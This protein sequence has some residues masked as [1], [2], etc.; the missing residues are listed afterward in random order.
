LH[1]TVNGIFQLALAWYYTGDA[2]Y[3]AQAKVFARHWFLD[4]ATAMNANMNFGQGIPCRPVPTL[5][6]GIG[7]IEF[8]GGY[9]SDLID[10]LAILDLGAP[11]WTAAD[12]AAMRAWLREFFTWLTT[13]QTMDGGLADP[14]MEAVSLNNHGSWYDSSVASL[15]AYLGE[16]ATVTAM[17]DSGKKRIDD[18]IDGTGAQYRELARTQAWHYSIYNATALCRLAETASQFGTNLWTYVGTSGGTV[19]LAMEYLAD[20]A[21]M[22]ETGFQYGPACVPPNAGQT[23]AT[24]A[25]CT[26][27]QITVV[28]TEEPGGTMPAFDQAEPFYNLHAAA[29]EAM[30]TKAAAAVTQAPAPGGIDMWPLI[31][32]CRIAVGGI[33]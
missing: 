4:A 3:A 13:A 30:S 11:G 14:I 29:A 12:Q 7:I 26:P 19:L 8:A 27:T 20:G 31:P 18:Q 9:L 17:I 33:P 5:G 25:K 23:P 28:P 24:T 1:S 16:T 22:G 32:S 21:A 2:R 15:A 10:G 6:R